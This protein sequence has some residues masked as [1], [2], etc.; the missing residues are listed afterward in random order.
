MTT[1]K[2]MATIRQFGQL[3]NIGQ[4]GYSQYGHNNE[5]PVEEITINI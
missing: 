2:I 3:V 4:M 5:E 1:I